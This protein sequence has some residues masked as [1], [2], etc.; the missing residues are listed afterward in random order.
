MR[1]IIIDKVS[2]KITAV[3]D[4]YHS[5]GIK[6]LIYV[7][8]QYCINLIIRFFRFLLFILMLLFIKDNKKLILFCSYEGKSFDDSP[9]SIFEGM[10]NDYRFC[11]YTFVWALIDINKYDI[12][13][14][15]KVKF[16][17]ILYDYYR[18]K[19]ICYITN[20]RIK[21]CGYRM[22]SKFYLNTWHG[23]PIKKIS[24]YVDDYSSCDI[25][26]AQGPY[27]ASVLSKAL[28]VDKNNVLICGLPRNDILVNYNTQIKI[29]IRKRL[30]L[31][32]NKRII[33]YCPTW[34]DYEYDDKHQYINTSIDFHKWLKIIGNDYIV[35]YRAH[36]MINHTA[37]IEFNDFVFD[38]S[39]YSCLS[40]LMIISDILISDYSS[41]FFDY[42]ILKKPMLCYAYDYNKYEARRGLI[43][44]ILNELPCTVCTK[45][46][47]LLD[48]IKNLDVEKSV[49]NVTA[50]HDKYIKAC[51]NA[52][53]TCIDLVWKNIGS[54]N[55]Q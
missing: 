22:K 28:N 50:F 1:K 7:T 36:N 17:S 13:N 40:D 45:E 10:K 6:T 44:D 30:K 38:Y 49:K 11:N 35:L 27:D 43:L 12:N 42:S 34:R 52:T 39:E 55:L 53:K 48:Q 4:I 47:I 2:K 16:G 33:L 37:G 23:I 31:P 15:I 20:M 8:M 5:H 9:K 24:G 21:S 26:C 19:A 46:E 14:A 18:V 29:D 32:E 25:L 51:G 3:N 54:V 41:I